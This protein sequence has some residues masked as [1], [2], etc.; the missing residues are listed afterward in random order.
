MLI[1]RKRSTDIEDFNT[2][3]GFY[4]PLDSTPIKLAF[5]NDDMINNILNY[6][7]VEYQKE[8][9]KFL[10]DRGCFEKGNASFKTVNKII[11]LTNK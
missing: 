5:N 4:Y 8:V 6:D 9:D 1:I 2:E 10:K 11:E 7:D 3:R